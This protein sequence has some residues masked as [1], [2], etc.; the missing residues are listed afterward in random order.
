MTRIAPADPEAFRDSLDGTLGFVFEKTA[1]HRVLYTPLLT[2]AQVDAARGKATPVLLHAPLLGGFFDDLWDGVKDAANAVAD[3]VTKVVVTITDTINLAVTT[4]VDGLE[5]IVHS[6]VSSVKDALNAIANFFEQI[7]AEIAKVIAFLRA[8]FDWGNIIETHHILRD[9]FNA[10]LDISVAKLRDS[11]AFVKNVRG[12][13]GASVTAPKGGKSMNGTTA[14]APE[15]E[16]QISRDANSVQGKSMTQKTKTTAP[17]S[18]G[19]DGRPAPDPAGGTESPFDAIAAALPK[20]ADSILDL[21]PDKLFEQLKAIGEAAATA[22]IISAATAMSEA[23]DTVA[24]T[25][26][27]TRNIL[28][29]KIEIPFVS[30]LYKW[31]TGTD[32]TIMSVLCLALAIPVNIAY[33]VFTL[34]LRGEARFFFNDGK[35]IAANMRKAAGLPPRVGE[36]AE[37]HSSALV[38]EVGESTGESKGEIPLTDPGVEFLVIL[39][40]TAATVA[41]IG[42]DLIFL[43]SHG[44]GRDPT[45]E[46]K[47]ELAMTNILQGIAGTMALSVQ[48]FESQKRFEDRVRYIVGADADNFLPPY[49]E[50]SYT[51]Y[52]VFMTLR[53]NKLRAGLTGYFKPDAAAGWASKL[54]DAVEYPLSCAGAGVALGALCWT[55]GNLPGR[56]AALKKYPDPHAATVAEEFLYM[57]IRDIL[58]LAGAIFEPLY[59]EKGVKKFRARFPAGAPWVLGA[60]ANT[61]GFGN[62]GAIVMHGI[63]V[64]KY[65]D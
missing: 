47:A 3:A 32:L 16:M 2:Q 8:L 17:T 1:K 55:L 20:L 40:R 59:T 25:M 7:G 29:A 14:S 39:L 52:G 21:S 46:Q 5:K 11:S 12:V 56:Y 9:I 4:M 10:S 54:K 38:N 64:Y 24:T 45:A 35:Q 42:A 53:A 41:D 36:V 30:E 15:K 51:I 65:G 49:I 31:V 27:W 43:R 50:V 33:A 28:N 19:D 6:V 61:R 23:M 58:G 37:V 18:T 13:A 62:L 26:E 48:M 60:S 57:T 63:A 44:S 34:L 22:G